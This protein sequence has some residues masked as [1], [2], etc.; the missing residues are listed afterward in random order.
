MDREIIRGTRV[1]IV[2]DTLANVE[3][4]ERVLQQAGYTE[5]SRT[6]DPRRALEMFGVY[7]PDLILLD[8]MMPH[9]DGLSLMKQLR[10]RI[11]E[12]QY[13]PIIVITADA[14]ASTKRQALSL[15]AK[16]FLTKPFDVT[17]ITL[18]VNNLAETRWLHMQLHNRLTALEEATKGR[19]DLMGVPAAVQ[20]AAGVQ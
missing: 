20:A 17:E 18:R 2:D 14:T 15:G 9:V 6:T 12:D 7:K 8:L 10:S 5:I 1:L 4:L 16:D 11:P 19:E 13:L 3:L